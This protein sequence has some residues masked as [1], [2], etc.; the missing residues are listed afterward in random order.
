MTDCST[1]NPYNILI[2]NLNKNNKIIVS[3]IDEPTTE[4]FIDDCRR[5]YQS[6]LLENNNV[7]CGID[8]EFNM[9][10]AQKM[11]YIGL[12]QIILIDNIDKYYDANYEKKIYILDPNRLNFRDKKKIIR[13][14]FL[15][16]VIKIFHGSDSLDYQYVYT[17]ILGEDK[18]KFIKFINNSVDTRFLCEISKRVMSRLNII[19]IT[20]K[21]CSLYNALFD[22]KIISVDIFDSLECI[23]SKIN[24]NKNWILKDLNKDQLYYSACDVAYLYDLLIY[25]SSS[26]K[27]EDHSIDIISVVNRLYR[28]HMINKLK[29]TDLFYKCK[30]IV[31]KYKI[32]KENMTIID[33]KIME[34]NLSKIIF[35]DV[36]KNKYSMTTTLEDIF[37][38][39]TIRKT[40]MYCLRVYRIDKNDSD[41][42]LID[43][44]FERD[45]LFN[46]MKGYNT[47]LNLIEMVKNNI[48]LLSI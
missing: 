20:N 47:I 42:Q 3:V 23:S 17:S 15:S 36:D 39:D 21:K 27:P 18:N 5:I 35:L 45:E 13:Y 40:I 31:D 26:I 14:I 4:N 44:E 16:N 2:S 7:F 37:N 9:N 22:H 38:I 43:N 10:W 11:R 24:Y 25:I 29:M 1:N 34:I 46:K 19:S 48:K 28:F 32:S 6:S 8:F 12:M 33:Q 30:S 41:T